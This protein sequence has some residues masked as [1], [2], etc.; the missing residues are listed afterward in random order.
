MEELEADISTKL[1]QRDDAQNERKYDSPLARYGDKLLTYNQGDVAARR[2]RGPGAA[3]HT[4]RA[5]Q[6]R[7][8]AADQHQQGAAVAVA[9]LV[10]LGRLTL[11]C[12]THRAG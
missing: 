4:H 12:R 8:H 2:G 11:S 6:G 7:A 5:G 9:V 10:V 1:K 3:G